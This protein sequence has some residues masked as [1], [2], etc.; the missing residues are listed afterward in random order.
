MTPQTGPHAALEFSIFPE[1]YKWSAARF[2]E[3]EIRDPIAVGFDWLV[4]LMIIKF[5]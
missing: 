3:Q 4:G 2:Y 5:C 1:G